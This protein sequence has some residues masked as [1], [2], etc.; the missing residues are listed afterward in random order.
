M[1]EKMIGKQ[2]DGLREACGQFSFQSYKPFSRKCLYKES[3]PEIMAVPTK[4]IIKFRE[5]CGIASFH[6]REHVHHVSKN[7]IEWFPH[8]KIPNF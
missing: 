1:A 6:Q 3:V 5:K 4:R 8:K 2:A 7:I